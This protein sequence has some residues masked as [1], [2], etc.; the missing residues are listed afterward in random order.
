MA[1]SKTTTKK[2]KSI[3]GVE[4]P[5]NEFENARLFDISWG[6]KKPKVEALPPDF[7]PPTIK[8]RYDF[9]GAHEPMMRPTK[10]DP[11]ATH[12]DVINSTENQGA[13]K[14]PRKT[15]YTKKRWY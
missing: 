6:K 8:L 1:A 13:V 9:N 5:F 15:K 4:N 11:K 10:A 7:E 14:L 12:V 3:E 2:E